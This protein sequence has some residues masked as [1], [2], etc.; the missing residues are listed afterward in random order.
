MGNGRKAK[1]PGKLPDGHPLA[2]KPPATTSARQVLI[3]A[4]GVVAIVLMVTPLFLFGRPE[5]VQGVSL[6]RAL[7][8]LD[9]GV[10]DGRAVT[11]V[12]VDDN[13]RAIVL[14]LENGDEVAA[15]YP[16][17]YGSS[18][19]ARL[20]ASEIPFA[21]DAP[22]RPSIWGTIALSLLP[23]FLLIGFL[24]WFMRRSGMGGAGARAFTATK[25][26]LGAVPATRFT[27]VV[28]CDEAVEELSEIIEF[29]HD[30]A[31]F[32][33]A[34]ARLPRG[35]L[36]VGPPGTGKTLLARAVAGEA[37]VPFY[38]CAGSDFTEMFVGVGAA[39]VR[40][41]F[42]K[43]KKTGGIVFVDELDSIGR[44]RS[45]T[46]AGGGGGAEEREGALNALL[47]EM[48]GFGKE[49]NIIVIGATNRPDVLDPALLRAGRFDR[50][51][52]VAPPDRKGRTRLLE[53][54]AQDR[55]VAPDVDFVAFA[56]RL[57]GL[58]GADIANLVNQA[59][60]EAARAGRE[61]ITA[62]DF[63]EALANVMMGRARRSATITDRDREITAWHEAGHAVVALVLPEA[64]DPVHVTIVPRGG[65]GGVTW[66]GGDDASF[67]TRPEVRARL[68]VS[69]AGRAGE[70]FL[71]DGEF[72]QGASN[73]LAHATVLATR[74]VTEWGMSSLGLAAV[75][76]E[77]A[78]SGLGERVHAEVD[79]LL[80][81]ALATARRVLAEHRAFFDAVVA[82]LLADET[83]DLDRLRALWARAAGLAA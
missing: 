10:I 45:G 21:T 6:A 83:V 60:L 15:H 49:D 54:Y 66:M 34:G 56:R 39:R 68:A 74:M 47:V 29:L 80:G 48:D 32:T 24:V 62:A 23:I 2:P 8:A 81:E 59:A 14:T 36:L 19:V 1:G 64:H 35:F 9:T 57:P 5:D 46:S 77:H 33:A 16:E 4:A 38:S 65:A 58:T 82:D 13:S 61:E 42:A 67:V 43:A 22:S 71:L 69:M 28:G 73:D 3:A 31:R 11:W 76:P 78:G 20:E 12:D 17:D 55:R 26:E 41:L 72:T 44:A 63:G 30:P 18:L 25:A 27:E 7:V 52:T 70:E 51:V 37:G 79:T 53:L 40:S 50:Q 75:G